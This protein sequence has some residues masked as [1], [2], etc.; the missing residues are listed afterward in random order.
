M[1]RPD[2]EVGDIVRYS[3]RAK[4]SSQAIMLVVKVPRANQDGRDKIKVFYETA[5]GIKRRAS[6]ARKL[7]WK[8]GYNIFKSG[9]NIQF[10]KTITLTLAQP[11]SGVTRIMPFSHLVG[12][13]TYPINNDY[14]VSKPE[15]SKPKLDEV[16]CQCGR[17]ADKGKPCWWCGKQN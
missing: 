7:L 2:L 13:A 12:P 8:T 15:Q 5:G 6:I 14:I 3:K 16:L 17:N 10:D 4:T 11:M 1:Q 9:K